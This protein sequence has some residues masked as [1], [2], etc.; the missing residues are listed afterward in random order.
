LTD[1]S[2]IV[3]DTTGEGSVVAARLAAEAF[4]NG[5]AG[6]PVQIVFAD[7]QLKPDVT[8]SIARKWFEHS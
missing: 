4:R 8:A 3:S 1:I 7:H 6:A 5:V 2:G